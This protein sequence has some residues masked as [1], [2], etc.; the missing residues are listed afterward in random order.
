[1]RLLLLSNSTN[2]GQSFLEHTSNEIVEF[3]GRKP[4]RILFIPYAIVTLS[5]DQYYLKVKDKFNNLGYEIESIHL[6]ADPA[7]SISTSDCIV[8]GGGNTFHLLYELQKYKLMDLIALQ[9]KQGTPYIGWSAGINLTCPTIKTTNDMPIIE[10]DNLAGLNLIPFQI[11]P[12]Y[13]EKQIEGHGGESRDMRIEEFLKIN[14]D[15]VVIGLRE[16]ST[17]KVE[18]QTLKLKGVNKARLFRAGNPAVEI[19]SE[20]DLSYLIYRN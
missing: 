18:S 14:R 4:S 10:T 12:H 20:D 6:S 3:L 19:S 2:P 11:N 16:G 8:V 13:T 5:Y 7:K 1:M 9:V 17:L 15:M